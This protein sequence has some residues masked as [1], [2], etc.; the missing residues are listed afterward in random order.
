MTDSS[1]RGNPGRKFPSEGTGARTIW[2]NRSFKRFA[3]V[4]SPAPLLMHR[5]VGPHIDF[6]CW[7]AS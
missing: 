4:L 5:S 1:P 3:T 6:C 7:E 2:F